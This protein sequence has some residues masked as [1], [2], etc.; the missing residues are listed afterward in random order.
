MFQR[1]G[2][3]KSGKGTY[4]AS[5]FFKID[6]IQESINKASLLGEACFTAVF[7]K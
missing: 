1:N 6:I 4:L 7:E 5:L 2:R 3:I